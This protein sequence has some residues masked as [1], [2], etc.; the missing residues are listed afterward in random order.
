MEYSA[1]R[2]LL[3]GRLSNEEKCFFIKVLGCLVKSD[4]TLAEDEVEFLRETSRLYGLDDKAAVSLI[5]QASLQNVLQEAEIIDTRQKALFLVSEMCRAANADDDFDD[6]EADFMV[7]LS[8][9]FGI[10]LPK[11]IEINDHL[12]EEERLAEK[13]II[14]LEL[15]RPTQFLNN[16]DYTT[17]S[18]AALPE[19][20]TAEDF[21]FDSVS[22]DQ[23]S[24][25]SKIN[26]VPP[27]LCPT[28]ADFCPV[29]SPFAQKNNVRDRLNHLL[30]LRGT[31]GNKY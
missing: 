13:S 19:T 27:G 22:T 16:A 31:G 15:D 2:N 8:E 28:Q 30:E 11:I 14:L 6:K 25:S 24:A 12:G 29:S 23:I 20:I 5:K 4:N 3:I 26:A 17:E 10:G 7:S 9:H 1:L 21:G 18:S